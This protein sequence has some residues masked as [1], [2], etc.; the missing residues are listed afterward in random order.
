M[1]ENI[2]KEF[3]KKF[4]VLKGMIIN[5]SLGIEETKI[6]VNK[7]IFALNTI[8]ASLKKNKT[9]FSAAQIRKVD[10]LLKE[11]AG[12]KEILP[13]LFENV[14]IKEEIVEELKVNL[15]ETIHTDNMEEN[16]L[17]Q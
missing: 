5:N 7:F 13:E 3:K 4:K 12:L 10:E 9:A 14:D 11:I 6:E 16:I 8:K 17:E 1:L 15:P 2:L